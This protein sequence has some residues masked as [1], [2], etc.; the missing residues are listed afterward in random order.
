MPG[1]IATGLHFTGQQS[2]GQ[3]EVV[4]LLLEHG[5]DA[6]VRD[7]DG[8]TPSELGSQIRTLQ[9]EI[10]ELLSDCGASSVKK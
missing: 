1:D 10:V 2:K 7:E 3:T 8:N 9:P 4:R 6:N 5:A